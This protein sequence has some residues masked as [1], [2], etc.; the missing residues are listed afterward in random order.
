MTVDGSS[1]SLIARGVGASA[2]CAAV[3]GACAGLISA[4]FDGTGFVL[5]LA[6]LGFVLGAFTGAVA[7][8]AGA[9]A[10]AAV[11]RARASE[12]VARV[13]GALGAGVAATFAIGATAGPFLVSAVAITTAIGAAVVVVAW[14]AVPPLRAAC[15][16]APPTGR[17][18]GP[19]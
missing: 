11:L 2:F 3:L 7:F 10:F 8:L 13:A 17:N 19:A 5:W 9:V 18:A 16:S 1:A 6:V 14:L 15:S 12:V 4:A